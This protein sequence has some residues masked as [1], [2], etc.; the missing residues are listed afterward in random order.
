MTNCRARASDRDEKKK[1]KK[2]RLVIDNKARD[3]DARPSAC[4]AIRHSPANRG[5][6]MWP[7]PSPHADV[8]LGSAFERAAAEP[9]LKSQIAFPA[10]DDSDT[11]KRTQKSSQ[12][13]AARVIDDDDDELMKWTHLVDCGQ[14]IGQL[15]D[16]IVSEPISERAKLR[17][18]NLKLDNILLAAAAASL[19]M[20]GWLFGA[21]APTC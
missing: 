8:V 9:M 3:D 18:D 15:T 20:S 7:P 1:K 21:L 4:Q 16:Q 11:D 13:S 19:V 17:P 6:A 14:R 5:D 10:N 12:K 2:K